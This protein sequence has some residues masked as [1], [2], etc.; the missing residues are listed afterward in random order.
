MTLAVAAALAAPAWA[1]QELSDQALQRVVGGEIKA[2]VRDDAAA[3]VAAQF[4]ATG[5]QAE[6]AQIS[7]PRPVPTPGLAIASGGVIAVGE[8]TINMSNAGLV[9][10]TDKA[11]EEAR[12][13]NITNAAESIVGN[14]VNVW[15]GKLAGQALNGLIPL[16]ANSTFQ[17]EQQNA[18]GQSQARSASLGEW[19][20]FS[21]N[22]N[23]L[24]KASA[25]MNDSAAVTKGNTSVDVLFGAVKYS[26]DKG[27][28]LAAAGN[29]ALDVDAGKVSINPNV[30]I[31]TTGS[32]VFGL[33]EGEVESQASMPISMD[34]PKLHLDV[35]AAACVADD[36]ASCSATR[37]DSASSEKSST[38][39]SAPAARVANAQA[40]Y[41][42]IGGGD[43][44][45]DSRNEVILANDAQR[46]ARGVN[47]VNAAS[48]VVG[49]GVNIA[50]M[51]GLSAAAGLNLSVHQS[52]LL[53]QAR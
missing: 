30:S 49:N 31:T 17:F 19:A 10:L 47:I 40:E 21:S 41:I 48:S 14:G 42:L 43:L 34:L 36:G 52:N 39:A 13:V 32:A 16:I 2:D 28:G 26:S 6:R 4:L 15:A 53:V 9:H 46:A 29:A 11:Q 25:S 22:V 45:V 23:T 50:A 1:G 5:L 44:T 7:D 18:I 20:V 38:L 8:A 3:A 33:I 51:S 24:E 35:N 27:R 37:N 12:G